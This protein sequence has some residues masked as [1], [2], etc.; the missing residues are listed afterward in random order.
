MSYDLTDGY[1]FSSV[2]DMSNEGRYRTKCEPSCQVHTTCENCTKAA[3][4]WCSN[5][6]RCVES[7]SYVASF[8]YGQCMEWTTQNLK[9]PGQM[10]IFDATSHPPP[11]FYSLF[12]FILF[13]F[14][15]NFNFI[16]IF[17]G[18]RGDC[19]FCFFHR[20]VFSIFMPF[21]TPF[22]EIL[23]ILSLKH[24]ISFCNLWA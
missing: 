16:F 11:L 8:P 20:L 22:L 15:F 17:F 21:F 2:T 14:N 19:L 7:N 10:V 1:K 4:M 24:R 12:Y 3:C 9:C 18:G 6:Q 13:Y 5:Q 23:N